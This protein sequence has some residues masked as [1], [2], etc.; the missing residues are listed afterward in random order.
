MSDPKMPNPA[1]LLAL[2]GLAMLLF[3]AIAIFFAAGYAPD[4]APAV[5]QTSAVPAQPSTPR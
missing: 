1:V 2:A 5:T 4:S 3:T